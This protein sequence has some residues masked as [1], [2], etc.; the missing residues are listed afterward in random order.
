MRVVRAKSWRE[1]VKPESRAGIH[2]AY[3][4]YLYYSRRRA[5]NKISVLAALV[6]LCLLLGL[7]ARVGVVLGVSLALFLGYLYLRARRLAEGLHLRRRVPAKA[8]EHD[9]IEIGFEL[10]NRSGFAVRDVVVVDGFAGSKAG[11]ELVWVDEPV[12]ARSVFAGSYRRKCDAGMGVFGFEPMT[13]IVSDPLGVFELIVTEDV[14]GRIEVYP[15]LEP[16]PQ[17]ELRGSRESFLY[18]IY[19]LPTRGASVNF[20]GIREYVRGDSLRHVAW[21]LSAR[22]GKLLVKEFEKIA[23]TEI[24]VLL[25][26]DGRDHVG[27][28]S[29]ST[30]E[31]AK[32]AALA[33]VTQQMANGNSLQLVSNDRRVRFG[34]GEAHANLI[35]R[36]I[37][38]VMPVND[39]SDRSLVER[40]L[41]LVPAASTVVFIG[42]LLHTDPEA[43]LRSLLKLRLEGVDVVC[44][45]IHPASFAAG[46][47]EGELKFMVESTAWKNESSIRRLLLRMR[48]AGID[49]FLLENGKPIA[50]SLLADGRRA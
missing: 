50:T 45:L 8:V 43:L 30:W 41:E 10:V 20:M 37:F 28:K 31:Y 34:R 9:E 17:L 19:D 26:M 48:Q 49:A 29:E 14:P 36:V 44:L 13:A 21:R 1:Y 38:D 7:S 15:K 42:P 24:T 25:N 47:V 3:R 11:R 23:N 18:G 39:R 4:S 35:A 46:K 6:A 2:P 22:N 32:D 40:S 27:R 5:I 12:A 33:V 16:I